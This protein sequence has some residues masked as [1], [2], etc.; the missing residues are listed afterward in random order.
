MGA[1]VLIPHGEDV[2]E[3]APR[4]FADLMAY[5]RDKAIEGIVWHHEDGRRVKIKKADFPF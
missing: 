1:H 5:L 4:T 2:L 3:D